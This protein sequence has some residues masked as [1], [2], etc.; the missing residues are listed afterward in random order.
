MLSLYKGVTGHCFVGHRHFELAIGVISSMIDYTPPC[1]CVVFRAF[2]K[3]CLLPS[4]CLIEFCNFC[5]RC[6]LFIGTIFLVSSPK[7]T[8]LPFL[9]KHNM[10]E[11]SF[12]RCISFSLRYFTTLFCVPIFICHIRLILLGEID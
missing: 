11:M 7:L 2:W 4:K 1:H 12:I 6:F 8:S 9:L 10:S 5:Q 3:I